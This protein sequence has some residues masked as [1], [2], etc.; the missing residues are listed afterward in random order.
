MTAMLRFK[1]LEAHILAA[2][3]VASEE[4]ARPPADWSQLVKAARESGF[5][6][7][8]IYPWNPA[9]EELVRAALG[10]GEE[11][12][13]SES[14]AQPARRPGERRFM[15]TWSRLDLAELR[16]MCDLRDLPSKD[17]DSVDDL[18]RQADVRL[19]Q[20]ERKRDETEK[21]QLL[22]KGDANVGIKMEGA[23]S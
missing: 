15:H 16:K 23:S 4:R 2:S 22:R 7:P 21:H 8:M 1:R 18:V 13:L 17:V 9:R 12:H 20:K 10:G 6:A 5:Q 14:E 3:R 19:N 11:N